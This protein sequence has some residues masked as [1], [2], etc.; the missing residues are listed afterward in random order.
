M[1]PMRSDRSCWASTGLDWEVVSKA[2]RFAG[3]AG[4]L[5]ELP[6]PPGVRA[7]VGGHPTDALK[8]LPHLRRGGVVAVQLDRS[9]GSGTPVQVPL[10]GEPFGV[11]AGPFRLA[12]LTGAAVV[13]VFTRR[14]GYFRHEVDVSA[15]IFVAAGAAGVTA[16]A[17]HAARAMERFLAANPT[18]WFHFSQE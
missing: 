2:A 11:P 16:A 9:A 6:A 8:L 10:G 13:P 15:P 7:H 17:E 14:V 18:Q 4:Q 12:Q 1:G 3:R 5:M